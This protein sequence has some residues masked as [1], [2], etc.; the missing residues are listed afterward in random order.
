M[1]EPIFTSDWQ[2]HEEL[3]LLHAMC[4]HGPQ[5]WKAIAD[6]VGKTMKKCENHYEHV[7]LKNENSPMPNHVLTSI[8]PSLS[9][10]ASADLVDELDAR[11]EIPAKESEAR[12]ET[13]AKDIKKGKRGRPSQRK[14]KTKDE[15]SRP[16]AL[17]GYMKMRGDFDV[18]YDD[19]AENLIADLV[20][21][22][23][24]TDEE[25]DLKMRLLSMYDERLARRDAVKEFIF[26]H[27]FLEFD[28][29]RYSER[30]GTRDEKELSARLQVFSKLLNMTEFQ[31]FYDSVMT[32]YRIS[33]EVYRLEQSR[34]AGVHVRSE[35]DIYEVE[36]KLRVS[37]ATTTPNGKRSMKKKSTGVAKR[38]RPRKREPENVVMN[39]ELVDST[40]GTPNSFATVPTPGPSPEADNEG[41]VAES[42]TA[43]ARKAREMRR[44]AKSP[45]PQ[46]D[47]SRIDA[48]ENSSLLTLTEK[49][50]CA[51]LN[52][53]PSEFLK[54]RDAMIYSANEHFAEPS[55]RQNGR[56]MGAVLALRAASSP[57]VSASGRKEQSACGGQPTG[58][59][60]E[61]Q[62]RSG[63]MQ[64][65]AAPVTQ[66]PRPEPLIMTLQNHNALSKPQ[67]STEQC[68]APKSNYERKTDLTASQSD[69][70]LR[71]R[72][73]LPTS[74]SHT[75][76]FA[77]APPDSPETPDKANPIGTNL[78]HTRGGGSGVDENKEIVVVR[79]QVPRRITRSAAK[80]AHA[81][82]E[83]IEAHTVAI[84][85]SRPYSVDN[86]T[87]EE[88]PCHGSVVTVAAKISGTSNISKTS[89][90][91]RGLALSTTRPGTPGN[92][93]KMLTIEKE[94]ITTEDPATNAL[95]TAVSCE[96]PHKMKDDMEGCNGTT[97]EAIQSKLNSQDE[98]DTRGAKPNSSSACAASLRPDY[99]HAG[100]SSYK[101]SSIS[102]VAKNAVV[103]EDAAPIHSGQQCA[104]ILMDERPGAAQGLRTKVDEAKVDPLVRNKEE[105]ESDGRG[106]HESLCKVSANDKKQSATKTSKTRVEQEKPNCVS[107]RA[108]DSVTWHDQDQ[109]KASIAPDEKERIRKKRALETSDRDMESSSGEGRKRRKLSEKKPKVF[110]SIEEPREEGLVEDE[111]IAEG[112]ESE[113]T[114]DGQ[115]PNI[116]FEKSSD[117][118]DYLEIPKSDG[119]T[120]GESN[121]EELDGG[122]AAS[123][124]SSADMLKSPEHPTCQTEITS[125][126]GSP[127]TSGC[128][129]NGVEHDESGS[130]LGGSSRNFSVLTPSRRSN[131]ILKR[132]R[133]LQGS[134][135]TSP[136]PRKQ[137]KLSDAPH[138]EQDLESSP[139]RD[140][141]SSSELERNT[142]TRPVATTR[143]RAN[144]K[145][146]PTLAR[147][148]PRT[149]VPKNLQ[150]GSEP[151]TP[152]RSSARKS[153]RRST[154]SE[155]KASGDALDTPSRSTRSKDQRYGLRSVRK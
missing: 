68:N 16:E 62:L 52:F 83:R 38:G 6:Y 120:D 151:S 149:S 135:D 94:V 153:A 39:E 20:I 128:D 140:Q 99:S 33:R 13:P 46:L 29:L 57:Q 119:A 142:P 145:L 26:N 3:R 112:K 17:E 61:V 113:G 71:L 125:E 36:R 54:L 21:L 88:Q 95:A 60:L 58:L 155:R 24:D 100:N 138:Q 132:S 144:A 19:D 18:E 59:K 154:A 110:V 47:A 64:G 129:G 108:P 104:P 70:K 31:A 75:P 134:P 5:H 72:A 139:D 126:P 79:K 137:R 91:Q 41:S 4:E 56:A 63:D 84:R 1:T 107:E 81:L 8:A 122:N 77:Q 48:M 32:E 35:V 87:G 123:L 96:Q 130:H 11:N 118:D 7:Y 34:K 124:D 86:T 80:K 117:S 53:T 49:K 93:K 133:R 115:E 92:G 2:A 131:R 106:N 143:K 97:A 69:S 103:L 14:L 66:P 30:R 102:E 27:N 101:N 15:D 105:G 50:A 127:D 85:G 90:Q 150:R 74:G 82:R 23:A 37:K 89:T 51:A 116:G 25:R 152:V 43:A 148:V 73:T 44:I 67:V 111:T 12:S 65:V 141:H 114:S 147:K 78:T 146:G 9:P 22:P 42:R 45:Y 121:E 109:K 10:A 55:Q 98:K 136:R 28:T 76:G 40:P